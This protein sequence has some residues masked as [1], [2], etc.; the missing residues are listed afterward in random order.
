MIGS[1]IN[2]WKLIYQTYLE[3]RI[4]KIMYYY[5]VSFLFILGGLYF[6]LLWQG[7]I[8]FALLMSV[9]AGAKLPPDT[10]AI[11]VV[12]AIGILLVL[13]YT[14]F[15]VLDEIAKRPN[16]RFS[17]R[18]TLLEEKINDLHSLTFT[19]MMSAERK[20]AVMKKLSDERQKSVKVVVK[21]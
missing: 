19:G 2:I 20:R 8:G 13:R 10:P 18:L 1:L 4:G 15:G 3:H 9:I 21:K 7:T 5:L 6:Y 16:E 12:Q 17:E 11:T 14:M